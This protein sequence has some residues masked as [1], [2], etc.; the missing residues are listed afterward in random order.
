MLDSGVERITDSLGV[1]DVSWTGRINEVAGLFPR[2][3]GV[4]HLS[5]LDHGLVWSFLHGKFWS[6]KRFGN[7][8]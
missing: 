7:E 2:I 3:G 1:L 6:P 5:G 4:V 8:L